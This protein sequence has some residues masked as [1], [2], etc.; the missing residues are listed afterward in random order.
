MPSGFSF[1]TQNASYL[2]VG[3][4]QSSTPTLTPNRAAFARQRESVTKVLFEEFNERIFEGR[5]P[6]DME[7]VWSNKLNKT[8]GRTYTSRYVICGFFLEGPSFGKEGSVFFEV[9]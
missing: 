9:Y 5:L 3:Q 6:P 4:I 2:I 1:I 7:V 8:A